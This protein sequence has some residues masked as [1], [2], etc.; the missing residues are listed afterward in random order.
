MNCGATKIGLS[1][2]ESCPCAVVDV[3]AEAPASD[4]PAGKRVNVHDAADTTATASNS[5]LDVIMEAAAATGVPMPDSPAGVPAASP[6]T[7][8]PTL[9]R[10][11]RGQFNNSG[12]VLTLAPIA[13]TSVSQKED[14]K[15]VDDSKRLYV[16]NDGGREW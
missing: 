8:A 10:N 4:G 13:D 16:V 5:N 2:L 1:C 14:N 12:N 9:N 6:V 11:C 3:V 7:A 15:N